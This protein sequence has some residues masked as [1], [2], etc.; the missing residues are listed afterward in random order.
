MCVGC[1]A[2]DADLCHV[3]AA[4][5]LQDVVRHATTTHRHT[6]ATAQPH[7]KRSVG[8]DII[9][10]CM[11]PQAKSVQKTRHDTKRDKRKRSMVRRWSNGMCACLVL[12]ACLPLSL[13]PSLP[14]SV[15]RGPVH[16]VA[17]PLSPPV[18][19]CS[20]S[21]SLSPYRLGLSHCLLLLFSSLSMRVLGLMC[22]S[23]S[24]GA[25]YGRLVG[26]AVAPEC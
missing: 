14:L 21:L 26:V 17:V 3:V 10:K 20:R 13:S 23:R 6:L 16:G 2:C 24:G 12:P 18:S 5:G 19:S 11:G 1:A 15:W 4:R 7:I 8:V 25:S 22:V 9:R